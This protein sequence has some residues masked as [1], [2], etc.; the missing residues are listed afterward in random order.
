MKDKRINLPKTVVFCRSCKDCADL[1]VAI[2]DKF[3]KDKTEP[4]GYP[5]FLEYCLVSMYTRAS[6]ASVKELI[7]SLFRNTQSTLRVLIATTAF[8]MGIDIP[9]IRQVYHWGAPSDLE[10]YLQEIGRA[11]RDGNTSKAVL[12]NSKG[13]HHVQKQMKTYGEKKDNCRHK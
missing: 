3:G 5:N 2:I 11:G 10:Q 7:M 8:S 9:D 4:P 13:N 12:I 1:Y 6:K